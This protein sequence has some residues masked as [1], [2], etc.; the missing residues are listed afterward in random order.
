MLQ[1]YYT[2][3]FIDIMAQQILMQVTSIAVLCHDEEELVCFEGV[4]E[5]ENVFVVD[6]CQH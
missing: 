4:Y 5:F 3:L 2:F 1:Q 6:G